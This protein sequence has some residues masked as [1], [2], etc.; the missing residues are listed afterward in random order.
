[1]SHSLIVLPDDTVNSILDPIN[2]AKRSLNIRMFLFT[3]PTLLKAVIAAKQRGVHVRVMLNPARRDGQSENESARK[4]L[5]DGDI[6]VRDSSP[7]FAITHQKSMVIDD[8]LG[9]VESLNWETRDLTE[10]RDYAVVTTK[11]IEVSEMVN[12]FEADWAHQEFHPSAGSELIWCPNNGRERIA[13][14]IDSAKETLWIQNERYQDTVIIER[15][16]RAIKRGVQ[17]H[18]MAR[19]AHKLKKNKLIEGIGGLRI[20][21][22]VGAKIHKL[23]D[24]K[25]HGKMLLADEER[26]IVGSIN[27]TPGSFDD[28]RE[29][30]VETD[31]NHVIKRLVE[32]TRHDWKHSKRLDL[33]D[34]GIL[35]DFEKHGTKG[36]DLLALDPSE[37]HQD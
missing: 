10:T 24:L 37:K 4:Q 32:T 22:D 36:A 31:S 20:M 28:R 16:V 21:H 5:T 25:L 13:R 29:L 34:A 35:A 1:M 15:L 9:F 11:K 7:D 17:V 30:A 2:A 19:P 3:D 33:S 26:A 18:I 27:L 14:F 6:E 8:E 23:K 12:C